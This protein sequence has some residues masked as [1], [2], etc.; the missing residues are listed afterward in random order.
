MDRRASTL[1]GLGLFLI[2]IIIIGC[3]A[4]TPEPV[5]A[6][7]IV[8]TP[9][10]WVCLQ[11]KFQ[12]SLEVNSELW[13]IGEKLLCAPEWKISNLYG[14]SLEGHDGPNYFSDFIPEERH[15]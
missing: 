7:Q 10:P 12:G 6:P 14:P 13:I 8:D 15:N 4:P 9:A 2:S 11:G 3:Q 1:L 5:L